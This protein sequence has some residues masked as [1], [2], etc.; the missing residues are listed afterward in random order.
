MHRPTPRRFLTYLV[1][2]VAIAIPITLAQGAAAIHQPPVLDLETLTGMQAEQMMAS[3]QLTSVELAKAYIERIEALNKRGPG[4]NAV[5]QY[6]PNALKEAAAS[7]KRRAAG[8]AARP[9]GRP[10]DPDE[11]PDR[12]EGHVHLGRQL[13]A[14]PL[15]P[16]HR[17][18]HHREPARARRR[19][20]RQARPDRVREQLRQP[21][22]RAS[23]NLTGQVVNGIDA[24]QNPS[25]SSS[26]TGSA[27]AAA[28]ST[29]GIGTE[30]SGSIISPSQTNGIVGLRPTVGLVP[31]DGIAP[32]DVSQD[33]AGPMVRTVSDA[34]LTLQSIAGPVPDDTEYA[35]IF[36]PDYYATGVIPVPP[37]PIPDYLSAL[38]LNFVN[39]KKIGYNGTLTAGSPLKIAYDALVAAG[40]IMV[41][42]PTTTVGTLLAAPERLRGAPHD[43][44][45]LRAARPGRR[46]S[47]PSS[48]RSPSTTPSRSRR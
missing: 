44:R 47:S 41:L 23:R 6:N 35:D 40:A 37:N 43:R 27:M 16:G 46:R 38:D 48:R 9:G 7:D 15:V 5:T 45:V 31:G 10:A 3:G 32:I 36:G 20:P 39:G 42:R 22:L 29:L 28:L 18:R 12:R 13:L 19:D 4:L 17:R 14:A 11:G 26:G 8:H 21:A 34:A 30:T 24:D 2:A 25:G 33:T 1:L